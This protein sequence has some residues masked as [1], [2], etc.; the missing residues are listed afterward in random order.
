MN[1]VIAAYWTE[2][3]PDEATG[4]VADAIHGHLIPG[5]GSVV[6]IEEGNVDPALRRFLRS[7]QLQEA[8]NS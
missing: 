5:T 6:S 2:D 1:L 3:D 4:Y 8:A 7:V